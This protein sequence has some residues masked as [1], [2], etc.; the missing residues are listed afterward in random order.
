MTPKEAIA[1]VE[2]R[3]S[4]QKVTESQNRQ[5]I[6]MS[7][8]KTFYIYYRLGPSSLLVAVVQPD[9]RL[10]NRSP[11]WV[12]CVGGVRFCIRITLRIWD[13]TD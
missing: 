11:K 1:A 6:V 7:L 5:Y 2:R 12:L 4:D 8:G 13:E 3:N 10:A 9:E